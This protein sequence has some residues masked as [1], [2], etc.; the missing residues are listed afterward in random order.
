MG[1]GVTGPG[2]PS[3]ASFSTMPCDRPILGTS[4]E[5]S[6][7]ADVP[8]MHAPMAPPG[9]QA[10][11]TLDHVVL[12]V[13]DPERSVAFYERAFRMEPVRLE[14]FR[15]GKAPFPSARMGPG[16]ILDFFGPR[17]WRASQAQNPHHFCLCL[18]P[19]E[20]GRLE[21]RLRDL[22][23]AV[24]KR[25]DHNFGARGFGRS[26]YVSDPDGISIEARCYD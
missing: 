15:E 2:A 22:G 23:I 7:A 21:E 1:G 11:A 3:Q 9:P 16:T 17:M 10:L 4:N 5:F 12:E 6:C 26:L 8:G 24:V 20:L 14:E 18:E 13:A 25:D 19:P